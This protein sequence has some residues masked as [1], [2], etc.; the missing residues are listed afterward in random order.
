MG[1]EN[2]RRLGVI[3][4]G[5]IG[6]AIAANLLADGHALLVHDTDRTRVDALVRLGAVRADTPAVVAARREITFTSLPGPAIMEAGAEAWLS[7]APPHRVLV[8]PPPN[9]PATTR[10]VG[11]RS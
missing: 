4:A 8:D 10:P 3:G 1:R 9:A 7:E 2:G 5:N 11:G 6:G